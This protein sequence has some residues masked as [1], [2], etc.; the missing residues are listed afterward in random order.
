MSVPQ[1]VPKW[2]VETVCNFIGGIGL[3]SLAPA[4][5]ENAVNGADLIALSDEEYVESLGCTKLQVR[6]LQIC[7][8]NLI[9][10]YQPWSAEDEIYSSPFC[11]PRRSA[12]SLKLME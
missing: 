1:P 10:C 7:I 5:K 4:F 9:L 11:R 12:G 2:D 8:G 6:V 3:E